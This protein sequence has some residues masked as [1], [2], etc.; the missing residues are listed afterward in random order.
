MQ[1]SH[2]SLTTDGD[3]LLGCITLVTAATRDDAL[4]TVQAAVEA[5]SSSLRWQTSDARVWANRSAAHLGAGNAAAALE[6]ARI[7]RVVQ[8]D[9]AK[10]STADDCMFSEPERRH[11]D[12]LQSCH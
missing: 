5:Y 3:C 12:T 4:M 2:Q 11:F 6:D 7:A 9:Y 10:V 8:P 1:R